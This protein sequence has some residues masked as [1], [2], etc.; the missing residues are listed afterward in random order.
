MKNKN[1]KYTYKNV[2][3]SSVCKL[4]I[5]FNLNFILIKNFDYKVYLNENESK[6]L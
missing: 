3:S 5:S 4:D 2:S 6:P 1:I